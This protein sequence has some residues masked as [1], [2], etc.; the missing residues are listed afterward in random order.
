VANL[1]T[2]ACLL[3]LVLIGPAQGSSPLQVK[4]ET[5]AGIPVRVTSEHRS[6][7]KT[8]FITLVIPDEA[9]SR[10][11]LELIWKHYCGKYSDKK[12]RLDLRVYINRSYEF[13]RQFEGWPV[14]VHTG[15][16]T[17]PNGTRV[18][19]RSFEAYFERMGKGALAYGG[20]NELMIYSPNINEPEKKER[21]V[22]A[23]EDPY[24]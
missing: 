3:L 24:W 17:G 14:N 8:Q 11:N 22:L 6:S 16:A 7:F 23:G 18:K 4:E 9:Y 1:N 15:E 10:A 12:D 21:I 13:N 5:I 2:A 19:L 20:D